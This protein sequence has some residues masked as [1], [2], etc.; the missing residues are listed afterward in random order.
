MAKFASAIT[1]IMGR[2]GGQDNAW[3]KLRYLL[4]SRRRARRSKS[5][6]EL[7]S[8]KELAQRENSAT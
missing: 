8:L 7:K 2:T 5:N 1:R 4:P 3:R 6:E